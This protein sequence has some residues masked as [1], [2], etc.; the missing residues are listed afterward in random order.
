MGSVLVQCP[1][2]ALP[3]HSACTYHALSQGKARP[4]HR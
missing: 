1:L 2:L 4:S 3:M